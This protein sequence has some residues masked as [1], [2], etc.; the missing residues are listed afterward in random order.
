MSIFRNVIV[1]AAASAALAA[2]RVSAQEPDTATLI[3]QLE[4]VNARLQAQEAELA[5]IRTAQSSTWLDGRRAEE[6]RAIVQETLED[7][8]TRSSLAGDGVAAGYKDGFFI[9]G[10]D[11]KFSLKINGETQIRYIYAHAQDR[12]T[13]AGV[14]SDDDESGFQLRRTRLNFTGHFIDPG[15]T[16]GI[17]PSFNRGNGNLQLDDAWVAI[18]LLDKLKVKA[19]QFK[20]AFLREENVSGFQQLAVERSYVADYFTL[21]YIQGLEF[22]YDGGFFKPSLT[23][24]DGSY[25]GFSTATDFQSDL[26]SFAVAGRVEFLVAGDWKQFR[27]F[28]SWSNDKTGVLIGLGADFE[29]GETGRNTNTPDVLKYTADVSVEIAGINFLAAGVGQQFDEGDGGGGLP[30]NLGTAQQWSAVLQ[31]GVFIIPDKLEL[32]ARYEWLDFDGVYYRNNGGAFQAG[33]RNL[34]DEDVLRITTIGGNWYFNKHASKFT[35]DALLAHDP[36]PVENSGGGQLRT[37]D[38][39]Q[40]TLRAQLQF[41]F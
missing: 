16:F 17:R 40:L 23:I 21:D 18:D 35:I 12:P 15:L 28:S 24:R 38:D 22:T 10:E 20:A 39:G 19:G 31:A 37:E 8:Q 3:R 1:T 34:N 33:S 9:A 30:T 25:S 29:R 13:G 5:R 11:G 7:A 6:I 27:D 41:R 14:D 4:Q 26:T 32:F 2:G 36:V